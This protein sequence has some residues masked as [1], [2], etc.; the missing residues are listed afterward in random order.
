MLQIAKRGITGSGNSKVVKGPGRDVNGVTL[1][2]LIW[3]ARNQ[4]MHYE[5]P[6]NAKT[7]G[8]FDT[9]KAKHGARF[10]TS[11]RRD[12]SREVIDLLDWSNLANY[13]KDMEAILP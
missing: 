13:T 5:S 8:V 3:A 9:L 2:D 4:A 6:L 10:D 12:L 7:Q 1:D 11:L